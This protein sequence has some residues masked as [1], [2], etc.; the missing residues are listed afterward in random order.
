MSR[1]GASRSIGIR[2]S[3]AG[4]VPVVR[5]AAGDPAGGL[6]DVPGLSQ[7]P[8]ALA[9]R[10][11]GAAATESDAV[12]AVRPS[13]AAR[14]ISARVSHEHYRRAHR[15]ERLLCRWEQA[16]RSLEKL[17]SVLSER[18]AESARVGKQPD[19]SVGL[20]NLVV[21]VERLLMELGESER[22]VVMQV[23]LLGL[24]EE[25]VGWKL[26]LSQADVSRAYWRGILRLDALL[27]G[28]GY[29]AR[30]Q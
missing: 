20:V 2:A 29:F 23:A 3:G 24:S 30:E 28:A 21:D 10:Q 4:F 16:S 6:A 8:G 5:A 15:T 27:E 12:G 13:R 22:R 19:L 17:V 18:L 9:G 25:W 14:G 26:R 1:G 11:G 7:P